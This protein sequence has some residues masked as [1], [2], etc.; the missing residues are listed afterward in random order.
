MFL[1]LISSLRLPFYFFHC[2]LNLDVELFLNSLQAGEVQLFVLE[3]LILSHYKQD[4]FCSKMFIK[5]FHSLKEKDYRCFLPHACSVAQLCPTLCNPM[6]CCPPGS[7]IHG[8]LQAR[9]LE[10][11]MISSFREFSA[12]YILIKRNIS[13]IRNWDTMKVELLNVKLCFNLCYA[14][15]GTFKTVFEPQFSLHEK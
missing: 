8:I 5:S 15:S 11:V 12:I 9:I 6:D 4:S 10:W 2:H 14:K 1:I 3:Q 7:S 13:G